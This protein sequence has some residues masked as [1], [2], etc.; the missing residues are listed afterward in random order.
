MITKS[1][2]EGTWAEDMGQFL[3]HLD[4]DTGKITRSLEKIKLKIINRVPSSLTKLA[5]IITWCLNIHSSIYMCVCVWLSSHHSW[6]KEG[7]I[8]SSVFLLCFVKRF[9]CIIREVCCHFFLSSHFQG[10]FRRGLQRQFLV[11]FFN[12]SS[13][14]SFL[15]RCLLGH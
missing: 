15:L 7:C 6:A 11:C 4:P 2:V 12:T 13:N 3:Y 9:S 14:S 1:M 8:L 10:I 5:S